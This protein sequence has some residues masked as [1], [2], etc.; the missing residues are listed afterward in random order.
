MAKEPIVI[1]NAIYVNF[2]VS[3]VIFVVIKELR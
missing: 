1:V 2:L 3:Y